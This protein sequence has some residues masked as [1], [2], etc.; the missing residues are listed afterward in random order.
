MK[1]NLFSALIV[2][3]LC[4]FIYAEAESPKN[5]EANPVIERSSPTA[6]RNGEIE[7]RDVSQNTASRNAVNLSSE[8]VNI[9]ISDI[10]ISI[11]K[12]KEEI[13]GMKN[14]IEEIKNAVGQSGE[15]AMAV[16]EKINNM[17]LKISR[18]EQSVSL[19]NKNIVEVEQFKSKISA[20][21]ISHRQEISQINEKLGRD[22]KANEDATDVIDADLHQLKEDI[23]AGRRPSFNSKQQF[24]EYIPYISIGVSVISFIIALH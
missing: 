7:S 4:P 12:M 2:F 14:S 24:K 11:I 9:T 21:D 18:L 13:N 17:E 22:I 3:T 15:G 5:T 8:P 6:V 23:A 19:L 1:K 20:S 16:Y 10:D